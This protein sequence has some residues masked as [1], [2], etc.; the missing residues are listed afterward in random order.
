MET[1]KGYKKSRESKKE[2][3]YSRMDDSMVDRL[4]EIR[5]K[6]G[7][8][9]SEIIREAVRRLFDEVDKTGSINLKI[10]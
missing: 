9:V 6:T 8:S 1:V 5:E 2:I 4:R 7:I 10:N 3:L